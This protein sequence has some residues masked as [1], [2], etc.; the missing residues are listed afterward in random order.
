VSE[1]YGIGYGA[2][3]VACG[4]VV[5]ELLRPCREQY[6]ELMSDK[7]ELNRLMK[8]GAEKAAVVADELLKD[9]KT[10]LGLPL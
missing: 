4:E 3:K 9:T 1:W 7:T 6:S 5:A 2:F 10:V 8:T